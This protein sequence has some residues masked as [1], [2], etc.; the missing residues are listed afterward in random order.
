MI[1]QSADNDLL[2]QSLFPKKLIEYKLDEASIEWIQ[3][4]VPWRKKTI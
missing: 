2:D 1:D 4:Y 3:L